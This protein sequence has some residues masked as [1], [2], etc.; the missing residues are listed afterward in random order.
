M[1]AA[2]S[3]GV[4][5]N[6]PD[7]SRPPYA[8]A[9]W[10][11]TGGA[12]SGLPIYGWLPKPGAPTGPPK[13]TGGA[14]T[15]MPT[16]GAPGAPTDTERRAP[17]TGPDGQ[18]HSGD[19]WGIIGGGGTGMPTYGW[20][21]GHP[22]GP[23]DE[24]RRMRDREHGIGNVRQ[25][26]EGTTADQLAP[27]APVDPTA[28]IAKDPYQVDY[29]NEY[30]DKFNANLATMRGAIDNA[31]ATSLVSLGARRDAAAKVVAGIPQ[32]IK[33]T[34]SQTDTKQSGIMAA[35]DKGQIPGQEIGGDANAKLYADDNVAARNSG[36]SLTPLLQAGVQSNYDLGEAGLNQAHLEGLS[37]LESQ[38]AQFNAG[39]AGAE[40]QH[41]YAL[42]DRQ[43]K[44][45]HPELDPDSRI[46]PLD[47]AKLDRADRDFNYTK[48]QT[49]G[50]TT[51]ERNA[52]AQG[53]GYTS[54]DEKVR[55]EQEAGYYA[56][57]FG[58]EVKDDTLRALNPNTLLA[59]WHRNAIS[60][61]QFY[62]AT[63]KPKP[64]K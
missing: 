61:D 1:P 13:I 34:Y 56:Q 47:Q 17:T 22:V 36:T 35:A 62:K 37:Q 46:S 20:V 58:K 42:E 7:P 16:Y 25:P 51:Y 30:V 11:V 53:E 27:T 60:D 26:G 12:G 43:F 6:T 48:N 59:L 41:N 23:S 63:G 18:T 8:G 39:M 32:Q 24:Q 29:N 10:G 50:N 2:P 44:I 5:P 52:A 19:T 57:D 64:K 55:A 49:E 14:G 15:G 3:Y 28:N 54:Y 9:K 38:Q 31:L 21:P 33:D 4:S 45:D 40:Q